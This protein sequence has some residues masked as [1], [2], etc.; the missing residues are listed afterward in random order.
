RG[1]DLAAA[2]AAALSVV[3]RYPKSRLAP[4]ALRLAA[5]LALRADQAASAQTVLVRLINAYPDAPELPG[6]LYL[7]AMTAEALG[8]SDAA[9]LTYRDVRLLAPASGYAEGAS[10]RIVALQASG[11]RLPP[12]TPGQ[13]IDRTE[14]LLR[15]HRP[16]VALGAAH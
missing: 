9:A 13:R 6:A 16:H 1:D 8:Q 7:L 3:D 14:R 4:R 10:D 11:I 15:A 12:L 5:T 2:R